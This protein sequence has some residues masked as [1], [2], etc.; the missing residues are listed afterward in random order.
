ML[1]RIVTGIHPE[2]VDT[3]GAKISRQVAKA[4]GLTTKAVQVCKV[5]TIDGLTTEQC[6]RLVDEAILFDPILQVAELGELNRTTPDYVIEVGFRPGVTDNEARTAREACA[7]A[8]NISRHDLAIYTSTQYRITQDPANPLKLSDI[9]NIARGFLCNTLI[10]RYRLKDAKEW[11]KEPGFP[12]QAAKVSGA[13]QD[14]VQT[15][16][17]SQMDDASLTKISR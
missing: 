10:Q 2:H 1:N 14:E 13:A 8:L 7:L 15:I 17:L 3:V 11:Q 4:L 5:F 12:P 16:Q 6:Q 9:E